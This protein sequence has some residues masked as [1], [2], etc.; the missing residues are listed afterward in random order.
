MQNEMSCNNK[1]YT[2][3]E[4]RIVDWEEQDAILSN[5]KHEAT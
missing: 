2:E 1:C 3:E 4:I 5:S